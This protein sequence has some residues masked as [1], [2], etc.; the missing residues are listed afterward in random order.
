M[1]SCRHRT[2]VDLERLTGIRAR[3]V[4]A[5]HEDSTTLA[6]DAA[7][8]CLAHSGHGPE[9][10]EIVISTSITK[11]HGGLSYRFEPSLSLGIKE[12][13]GARGA[14]HFDVSSACAGML[15]GVAILDAFIR[16]GR[17]RCGMV[18]SGEYITSI[19]DNARRSVRTIASRQLASLTVGDAGA[20]VILER[21]REGARGIEAWEFATY[22]Q[23]SHLCIGKAARGGP[24]AAMF[25][26]PRKLHQLA[27]RSC[28]PS[29]RRVLERAGASI[30]DV[31][32]VLPHQ[33]SVRAIRA[34]RKEVSEELGGWARHTICSLEEV[35]NTASTT[36]FVA[37]HRYL[38]E[39]R[40]QPGERVLM[41]CYAS[42]ITI[43]A[44][45][46]TMDELW[47]RYGR[48]H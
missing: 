31:D 27:I 7:W 8:D 44:L 29:I 12:A 5:E 46:F 15:T 39:R 22:G 32:W 6:V 1:A 36:H 47:E 45:L 28:T 10:V 3:R 9:D 4:C 43:G 11:Y 18:V 24:G 20:A 34:G 41:L 33:T 21:A 23:Y 25:T 14:R 13:I 2:G 17:V 37:L 38:E 30:K 35:G 40:I 42:G 26:R 48:A 19:A 16:S